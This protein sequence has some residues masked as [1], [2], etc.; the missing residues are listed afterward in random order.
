MPKASAKDEKHLSKPA[1]PLLKVVTQFEKSFPKGLDQLLAALPAK[2]IWRFIVD[3]QHQGESL[4]RCNYDKREPGYLQAMTEAFV[5]MID[6]LKMPDALNLSFIKTLHM[7]A[8][9]KVSGVHKHKLK[10][11]YAFNNNKIMGV[12]ISDRSSAENIECVLTKIAKG[13]PLITLSNRYGSLSLKNFREQLLKHNNDVRKMA[14]EWSSG[15]ERI[16]GL[17]DDSVKSFQKIADNYFISMIN[18]YKFNIK[19]ASDNREKLKVIVEFIAECA[20]SHPYV[21]GNSRTFCFLLLNFL[22]MTNGFPPAIL[23][24]PNDFDIY[25]TNKLINNVIDGMWYTLELLKTKKLYHVSM[26]YVSSQMDGASDTASVFYSS[27]L[28]ATKYFKPMEFK[29]RFWQFMADV[30]DISL[31]FAILQKNVKIP[32]K[33]PISISLAMIDEKLKEVRETRN[34]VANQTDIAIEIM[35]LVIKQK[36]F[37]RSADSLSADSKLFSAS[38]HLQ[39]LVNLENIFNKII[40][41][42]FIYNPPIPGIK[43][44]NIIILI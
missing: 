9:W 42:Y 11:D 8:L 39:S 3:G 2:E 13:N 38:I 40:K 30:T 22:L 1:D 10:D 5:Y 21:D 12:D 29:S 23:Y 43:K 36:E 26:D 37:I 7:Q 20:Q 44:T 24:N 6:C 16:H 35:K 34:K 28:I 15:T 18:N 32:D 27:Y 31:D 33:H 19:K 41:K 4:E 25:E 14:I 17:K